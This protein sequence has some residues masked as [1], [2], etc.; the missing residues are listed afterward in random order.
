MNPD[1]DLRRAQMATAAEAYEAARKAHLPSVLYRPN[2]IFR[3]GRWIAILGDD[4]ARHLSGEGITPAAAME[5]FDILFGLAAQ[6][7]SASQ[8][9]PQIAPDDLMAKVEAILSEPAISPPRDITRPLAAIEWDR[10]RLRARLRT[11]SPSF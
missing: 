1:N 3:D 7:L 6:P 4:P 5:A 9:P 10:A 2:L 11:V 8:A